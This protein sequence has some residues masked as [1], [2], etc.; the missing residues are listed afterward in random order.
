MGP[1]VFDVSSPFLLLKIIFPHFLHLSPDFRS[2]FFPRF[3][4]SGNFTSLASMELFALTFCIREFR[5]SYL[6]P[7]T[8]CPE[9]YPLVFLSPSI[10][11]RK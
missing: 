5:G 9:I 11:I 4:I 2:F 10:Q 1:S 3:K 6:G 7:E 8:D